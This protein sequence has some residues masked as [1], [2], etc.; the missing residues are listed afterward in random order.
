ML[1]ASV[2]RE[3]GLAAPWWQAVE[4]DPN[5]A[6]LVES[7]RTQTNFKLPQNTFF[8]SYHHS[9]CTKMATILFLFFFVGQAGVD[10]L[11][12]NTILK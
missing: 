8:L 9:G 4:R 3:G 1:E 5:P 10:M 2:N 11:V 12:P 7:G 6:P